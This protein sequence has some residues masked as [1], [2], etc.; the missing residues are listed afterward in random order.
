MGGGGE[1]RVENSS[2]Q[3]VRERRKRDGGCNF[4]SIQQGGGPACDGR[5]FAGGGA[6]E[7]VEGVVA[8]GVQRHQLLVGDGRVAEKL[9]LRRTVSALHHCSGK[10]QRHVIGGGGGGE[11]RLLPTPCLHSTK[12]TS[13][14]IGCVIRCHEDCRRKS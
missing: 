5:S 14:L 6:S 4:T 13:K 2:D 1:G 9:D 8:A 12:L 11:P 7:D 10:T 3:S